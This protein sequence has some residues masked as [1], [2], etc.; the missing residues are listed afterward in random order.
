LV[1]IRVMEPIPE[2][3]KVAV[4]G[5]GNGGMAIAAN[6]GLKGAEV[7]LYDNNAAILGE[8]KS[9]GGITLEQAGLERFA[10]ISL[11]TN[12]P[13]SAVTGADLIMVVTPA[14]AHRE[15]AK[16]MAPFL[17]G[18]MTIVLNPGRTGGALEVTKAL[19]DCHSPAGIAV[20]EAQTLLFACRK[21]TGSKVCVKGMKQVV[22][23]ATLPPQHSKRTVELLN[24]FFPQFIEAGNVLE[25]SIGNIGAIF[26]PTP[27]LL[28]LARIETTHG[29]FDYYH[30]GISPTL[31]VI[32]ER[33]DA[34]RIAIARALGISVSSAV[35]WLKQTY[36][37]VGANLYEAIQNN[38]AYSGIRGPKEVAVRYVTED[39]PT[40]LVPIA[41]L[42]R[43]CDV[44]T[45]LID[46]IINLACYALG[47]NF[48]EEGRN[49][50]NLGLDSK[51]LKE[52]GCSK[53]LL[54]SQ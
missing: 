2:H 41:S 53:T 3:L 18:G 10:P 20:A 32:L 7:R 16:T 44:P 43:I 30:E 1:V 47:R 21:I 49:V 4:I 9:Q 23:V 19:R 28:N 51:T 34:E 8:I 46:T 38:S 12:D 25:T 15:V 50:Q 29:E 48:W 40:G 36:G 31:A 11:V 52:I 37:V 45:P 54:L 27:T 39:V 6:L 5:A 33:I 26:H 42:G 13:Q 14:S 22:P 35:E 24:R 17:T